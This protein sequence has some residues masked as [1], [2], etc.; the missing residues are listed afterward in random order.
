V[1]HVQIGS[2]RNR[3][4]IRLRGTSRG[5]GNQTETVFLLVFVV[6]VLVRLPG[7]SQ[8]EVAM[9]NNDVIVLG[10]Q[11]TLDQ[12]RI[13]EGKRVELAGNASRLH[14]GTAV[15]TSQAPVYLPDT[16][17]WGATELGRQVVVEGVL[18]RRVIEPRSVD[19]NG[20][21]TAGGVFGEVFW[22]DGARLKEVAGEEGAGKR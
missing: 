17:T 16:E 6:T 11:A 14:A 4:G 15:L 18:R 10:P 13:A 1:L 9:R 7:C 5:L 8:H 12:L 19:R 22:I 20:V 3:S 21:P 2:S